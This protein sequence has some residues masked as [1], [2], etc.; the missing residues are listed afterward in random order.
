MSK[1]SKTE[2]RKK[3]E[4]MINLYQI[5][6]LTQDVCDK[7]DCA[8][9]IKNAYLEKSRLTHPDKNKNNPEMAELFQLIQGAYEILSDPKDR[10]NYNNRLIMEKQSGSSF[11][12]LK[13]GSEAYKEAMPYIKATDQQELEFKQRM[14]EANTHRGHA[15]MEDKPIPKK[16]AKNLLKDFMANRDADLN[17]AHP[18][19]FDDLKKDFDPK[20]FNAAFDL[21][22]KQGSVN[23]CMSVMEAPA[24]PLA[25]DT[26][27]SFGS[28]Y[29][30]IGYAGIEDPFDDTGSN[31]GLSG[32]TI[33]TYDRSEISPHVVT[34]DMM[35][36]IEGGDYYQ[37]HSTL[38]D[39]YV[40]NIKKRL[41]DR[42]LDSK[43]FVSMKFTDYKRD[44]MA[45]YGILDQIGYTDTERI[46]ALDA[47]SV[48]DRFE[49]LMRERSGM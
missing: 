15:S 6:G 9:L 17:Y 28:F 45:G 25:W 43:K 10:S 23:S 18:K 29:G 13:A 38:E 48:A 37:S 26:K 44:D 39:D 24:I 7:P 36:N 41:A 16:E 40:T 20:K 19:L 32:Q 5:L 34:R 2:Y 30:D 33:G 46:D 42:E 31:Y 3:E 1:D 47:L 27:S 49:K 21:Q 4:N 8:E 12:K 35:D 22:K 14:I 11:F